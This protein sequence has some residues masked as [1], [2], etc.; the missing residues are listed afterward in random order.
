MSNDTPFNPN[1]ADFMRWLDTFN[2]VEPDQPPVK[3]DT[4]TTLSE[5]NLVSEV[6]ATESTDVAKIKTKAEGDISIQRRVDEIDATL[7]SNTDWYNPA[8]M[9]PLIFNQLRNDVESFLTEDTKTLMISTLAHVLKRIE[10]LNGLIGI[11]PMQSPAGVVYTLEYQTDGV[12]PFK[13]MRL[14]IVP[15]AVE[16]AARKVQ[17]SM[18]LEA[19]TDT[20]SVH[21]MFIIDEI[22]ANIGF[23]LSHEILNEWVAKISTVAT[24]KDVTDRGINNNKLVIQLNASCNDI[25]RATRRGTGNWIIVSSE[26]LS[27]F[28]AYDDQALELHVAGGVESPFKPLF[29]LTT[30]TPTFNNGPI[31]RVG[32]FN[33]SVNVYAFADQPKDEI[34]IGY[35]GTTEADTGLLFC[36]YVPLVSSGPVMDHNTFQPT[37]RLMTRYGE[38]VAKDASS[39]YVRLIV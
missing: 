27:T 39:Y 17:A 2:K 4:S 35:K 33:N 14:S 1:T 19:V 16:A 25:G 13:Q 37:I 28:K 22:S 6:A 36:P 15:H 7:S 32:T 31:E 18:S 24:V 26:M 8:W 30:V 12:E 10:P 11:Q 38:H 21:S 29:K 3:L 34:L 23:N 9:K 5:T 20:V